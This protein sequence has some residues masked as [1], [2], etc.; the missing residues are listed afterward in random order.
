MQ[1]LD[2]PFFFCLYLNDD[3]ARLGQA[4]IS[5]VVKR[6]VDGVLGMSPQRIP[7]ASPPRT[8]TVY[9]IRDSFADR[10]QLGYAKEGS[11]GIVI[12]VDVG[13]NPGTGGSPA[14]VEGC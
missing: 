6:Y 11:L 9:R 1:S 14:V 4:E 5:D 8:A 12:Y 13:G 10:I 3:T 7:F 2:V